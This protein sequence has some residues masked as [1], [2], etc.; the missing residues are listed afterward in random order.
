ML[1][2]RTLGLKPPAQDME[3]ISTSSMY[4]LRTNGMSRLLADFHELRQDFSP[5]ET[6]SFQ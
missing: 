6:D 5:T 4:R 2:L 1:D 3:V